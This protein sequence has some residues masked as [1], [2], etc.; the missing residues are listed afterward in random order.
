MSSTTSETRVA[1]HEIEDRDSAIALAE[2]ALEHT[3]GEQTEIVLLRQ[4]LALTRVGRSVISQSVEDEGGRLWV[5]ARNGRGM[6]YASTQD[7]SDAGVAA[8]VARAR[9]LAPLNRSEPLDLPSVGDYA[10]LTT[11]FAT[12]TSADAARRAALMRD[13]IENADGVELAGNLRVAVQDLMVANSAGLR[14]HAPLSY[15]ALM[16]VA[17]AHDGATGHATSVSRDLATID[18]AAAAAAAAATATA[19]R[20]A[21]RLPPGSYRVLLDPSA[22]ATLLSTLG[23][24]G[25]NVF[26]AASS[27]SFMH[28]HAGE[29]VASDA[30]TL[31]DDPL[32]AQALP[33]AFDAEGTP[34]RPLTLIDRG[35]A[36]GIAHDLASAA[37]T[38]GAT[39]GHAL[40]VGMKGPAPIALAIQPGDAPRDELVRQ[41][42]RGLVVKRLHTFVSLRGGPDGELSGTTRDGVFV[43]ENGEVVGSA[44]NVRWTISTTALLREVEAVSRER[45]VGFMDLPEHFMHTSHVPSLLTGGFVV[46]GSQ[47]R[48]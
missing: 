6:G 27:G 18:P 41:L 23:Y 17:R 16:L 46:H 35:I 45:E 7:L 43:V 33:L 19:G 24:V 34:R 38:D 2:R 48:E 9:E 37:G 40:P 25:L 31:I 5:R 22:V 11:S 39:T 28:V 13:A 14:A 44:Q 47:P 30:I 10:Q 3:T 26:S 20:R 21:V 15:A 29:R 4:R 1:S 32:D 12:T 36:S 42:D 8:A